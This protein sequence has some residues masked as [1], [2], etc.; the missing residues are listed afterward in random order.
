M[1]IAIS[2]TACQ[3][4]TTLINDFLA[5][6]PVYKTASSTYRDAIKKEN[7]PHSKLATKDTQW[8]ILNH[9]VDELQKYGAKEKVIFDRCPIDN[10]VYSLWCMEKQSSDIDKEFIDKCIPIV[11]ESM[12]HLDIIFFTPITRVAPVKIEK[13]GLR[14]TD[15]IYIK[16]IDA[17][18]KALQQQQIQNPQ[19][20]PFFP[21]DDS[22]AIIE[23]FGN[24]P[25]RIQMVKLYLDR[26]G[27]LIGGDA[28][29]AA[30]LFNPENLGEMEALLKSTVTDATQE[31]AYKNE[32][33]KIKD[34]VK[35]VN[36]KR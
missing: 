31:K 21:T 33:A 4:K 13:G 28:Q 18:F 2:G 1:R 30:N 34:F 15:E 5:E 10:L 17:I 12:R 23:I 25:E 29:S 32:I 19:K 6:W 16:E 35:T 27:D 20:N 24:R 9:M 11:R 26:D 7:L 3:G 22:P 14:E 36:K 8:K